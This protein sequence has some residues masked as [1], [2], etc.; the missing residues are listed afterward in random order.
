VIPAIERLTREHAGGDIVAVTHGGTIRAALGHALEL[1]PQAA[2]AF[3][4]D[5]CSLTRLDHMAAANGTGLWRVVT[6]NS[7]PPSR[8]LALAPIAV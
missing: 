8:T 6:V 1:A 5:N 7:R 3:A 2:L 4:T